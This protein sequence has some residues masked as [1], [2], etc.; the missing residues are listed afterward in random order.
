M[1]DLNVVQRLLAD[2]WSN[3]VHL[4]FTVSAGEHDG[5][6]YCDDFLFSDHEHAIGWLAEHTDLTEAEAT[7]FYNLWDAGEWDDAVRLLADHDICLTVGGLILQFN[8][9]D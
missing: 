6:Q 1:S 5:N 9:N 8:Y 3:S 2:G 7:R 4:L